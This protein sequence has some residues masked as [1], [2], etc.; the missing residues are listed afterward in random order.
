MYIPRST[1]LGLLFAITTG[2]QAHPTSE[3]SAD[4]ALAPRA[5][6][7]DGRCGG[8]TGFTCTGS[9]FGT[10]CSASGFCGS[11]VNYCAQG[12]QKT[13]G[14]CTTG[15]VPSLS[16]ECGPKNGNYTCAGGPLNGQCCSSSGY[17]GLAAEYCN[18]GCQKGWGRC[19]VF[20]GGK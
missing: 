1:I 8:T 11:T 9:E 19:Y 3:T 12:C 7:I 4:A 17:C 2:V 13:A 18:D 10:C 6:S 15:V 20:T 16:G 14:S 5:I